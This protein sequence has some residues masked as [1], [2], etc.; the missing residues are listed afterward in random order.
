MRLSAALIT[1]IVGLAST[2]A[3]KPQKAHVPESP[4]STR[5]CLLYTCSAHGQ[6]RS[7]NCTKFRFGGYGRELTLLRSIREKNT[8]VVLIEGGDCVEWTGFQGDLKQEVT[9]KALALLGYDLMVPGEDELGRSGH[10]L[11]DKFDP[12]AVPIVCANL[13]SD[14]DDSK[15][16]YAPS[17][18]IK[19]KGGLRVGIVG[20]IDPDV[21]RKFQEKFLAGVISEPEAALKSQI[22]KLRPSADVVAVVYHGPEQTA[23]KLAAVK[24]VDLILATHR[25]TRD[26]VFPPKDES[27]AEAATKSVNG[28]VIANAETKNNWSLGQLDIE[29]TKTGKIASARHT[30]T[31]L[32]RNFAEDPRMLEVYESYNKNVKDAVLAESAKLKADV[33]TMLSKR[34]LNIAQMR[35]R[36]HKSS[37]ATTE[38]CKQ[39]HSDICDGWSKTRH[40]TAMATLEKTH[41]EYDPE[42]IGCHATGVI[43]RNGFKNM[44][45]TPKLA[46]VQCES[47]HGAGLAHAEKPAKGYGPVTEQTC[48]ACHT[49]E[50]TPEFNYDTDWAKIK[51]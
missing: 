23:E 49:D 28:V 8:D 29:F 14:D 3:V 44:K 9:K 46:N 33:E 45:E 6:I 40:A 38:M 31:Y 47:C 2:P 13:M 18:I 17:T 24:G 21:G 50:R 22:A 35:E 25:T 26:V 41:Q 15:L 37:F 27:V 34:G 39:C 10:K 32:D 48:R 19:T 20:L 42:C 51:H 36:L 7:C 11:I 43:A 30:V 4:R 16:A 12:K 5:L 1:L